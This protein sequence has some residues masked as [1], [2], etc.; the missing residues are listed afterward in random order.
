MFCHYCYLLGHDLKHCAHYFVATKNGEEVE[1]QYREWMKATGTRA[2]SPSSRGRYRGEANHGTKERTVRSQQGSG[3]ATKADDGGGGEVFT[4]V[5]MDTHAAGTAGNYGI[6]PED[7][8]PNHKFHGEKSTEMEGVD[9]ITSG[10]EDF[11]LS[12]DGLGVFNRPMNKNGPIRPQGVD[13][14]SKWT[15]FTRMDFGFVDLL[16]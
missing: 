6:F 14:Q 10:T 12:R 1:C 3:T 5:C 11:S 15:R 4:R 16:K 7:T 13:K 2:C 9:G 8:L